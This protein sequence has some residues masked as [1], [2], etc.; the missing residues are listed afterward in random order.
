[1]NQIF[2]DL[3]QRSPIKHPAVCNH[4]SD[5]RCVVD[6]HEWIVIQQHEVSE[7]SRCDTAEFRYLFKYSPYHHVEKGVKYPAVLLVTGDGDTRVDPLYA[8]KMA[9]LLQAS[10]GSSNPILLKYDT[11]SG[12]SGGKPL[13]ARI[14]D[15]TE[16]TL[17]LNH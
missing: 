16:F 4:C 2:Q 13:D 11:S 15:N 7:L 17:F 3:V 8:R 12:H 9:A 5:F 1:M 6:V 14:E 10:T